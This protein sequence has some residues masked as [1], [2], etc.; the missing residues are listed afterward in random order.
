MGALATALAHIFLAL[1]VA[2]ED[3]VTAQL[4]N[5]VLALKLLTA[6]IPFTLFDDGA[7]GGGCG[8]VGEGRKRVNIEARE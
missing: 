5:K 6:Q 2:F 3:G 1:Q 7:A 8:L 4:L